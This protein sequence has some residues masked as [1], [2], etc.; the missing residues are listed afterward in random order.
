[1]LTLCQLPA[2]LT[3]CSLCSL[4]RTA[5]S[6]SSSPQLSLPF[7]PMAEAHDGLHILCMPD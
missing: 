5:T 2:M 7:C 1:M 6:S 4:Q 3:L